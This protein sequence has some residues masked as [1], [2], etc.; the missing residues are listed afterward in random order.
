MFFV[1]V[2][3]ESRSAAK[4]P[5]FRLKQLNSYRSGAAFEMA[6]IFT[7]TTTTVAPIDAPIMVHGMNVNTTGD[8]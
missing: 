4:P 3:T 5:E 7:A 2:T 6:H 1:F 8:I